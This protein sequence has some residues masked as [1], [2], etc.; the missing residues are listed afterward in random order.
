MAGMTW[1]RYEAEVAGALSVRGPK[2]ECHVDVEHTIKAP[3][4]VLVGLKL[5]DKECAPCIAASVDP[6]QI[7]AALSVDNLYRSIPGVVLPFW[8]V[9][10]YVPAS[11]LVVVVTGKV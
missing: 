11:A 6:A 1:E 7:V 2:L 5:P 4:P 9:H 3:E 10:S 8:D